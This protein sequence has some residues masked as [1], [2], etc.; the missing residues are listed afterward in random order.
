MFLAVILY[1]SVVTD[2]S[3]CDVMMRKNHLFETEDKCMY[4]IN[5]I[6]QGL[7]ATDH[8][9]KAKCFTFIPLRQST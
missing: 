4:E 5:V 2:V 8:Y 6:A 7:I 3:T 1:C 9:V